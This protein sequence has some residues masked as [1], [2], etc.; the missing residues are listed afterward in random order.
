MLSAKEGKKVVLKTLPFGVEQPYY[1]TYTFILNEVAQ[2]VSGLFVEPTD[3]WKALWKAFDI[4]IVNR[5]FYY[6]IKGIFDSLIQIELPKAT[7]NK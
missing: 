5:N 6:E 1:K 3:L 7:V 4:S 2:K